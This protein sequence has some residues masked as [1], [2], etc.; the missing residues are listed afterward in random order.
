MIGPF[1]FYTLG[2]VFVT[3]VIR[4]GIDTLPASSRIRKVMD[5]GLFFLVC[6]VLGLY[7][8]ILG[9]ILLDGQR[10]VHELP[11]VTLIDERIIHGIGID[12]GKTDTIRTYRLDFK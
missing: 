3:L 11:A 4:S 6:F 5:S 1:L 8:T 10:F 9:T 7:G 2:V 12:S